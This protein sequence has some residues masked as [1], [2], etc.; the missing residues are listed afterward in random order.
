VSK[1]LDASGIAVK[2]FVTGNSE[3]R[4]TPE[5]DRQTSCFLSGQF[6]K[7]RLLTVVW[8][9]PCLCGSNKQPLAGSYIYI[10]NATFIRTTFHWAMV[11]TS[12]WGTQLAVAMQNTDTAHVLLSAMTSM[13]TIRNTRHKIQFLNHSNS[14][15]TRIL[16]MLQGRTQYRHR[17]CAAW[18]V[19]NGKRM[20][21]HSSA[22]NIPKA[23][24]TTETYCPIQSSHISKSSALFESSQAAPACPSGKSSM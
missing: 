17:W 2:T 7:W 5:H 9:T 24:R 1:Q 10:Y 16:I 19:C 3:V 13:D 18:A 15:H 12:T 4:A 11:H 22:L 21:L 14:N 20:Q 6:K 23:W 8:C